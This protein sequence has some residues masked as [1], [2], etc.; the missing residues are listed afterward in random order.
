MNMCDIGTAAAL[1]R[2][3]AEDSRLAAHNTRM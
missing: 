2:R 3:H 1:Q